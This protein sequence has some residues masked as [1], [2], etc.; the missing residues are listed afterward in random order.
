MG[1][2]NNERN[3]TSPTNYEVAKSNSVERGFRSGKESSVEKYQNAISNKSP[4][5][6]S[7]RNN[8]ECSFFKKNPYNTNTN[9]AKNKAK[10]LSSRL[11]TNPTTLGSY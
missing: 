11:E 3:L 4:K 10:G 2:Y 9:D 6:S 8:K 5:T 7:K 1:L